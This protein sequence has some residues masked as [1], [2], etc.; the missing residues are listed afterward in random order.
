M[1]AKKK[2]SGDKFSFYFSHLLIES[3]L[4][5][6]SKHNKVQKNLSILVSLKFSFF[7]FLRSNKRE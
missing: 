2:F 7:T 4:S 6:D 3:V 1:D 5:S